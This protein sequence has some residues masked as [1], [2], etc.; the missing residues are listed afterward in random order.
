MVLIDGM[1]I[2]SGL[3][4]V[5]GLSGIPQSLI[6]RIEIVK[7]PASTLYGSEA[8]GGLINIITKS[9]YQAPLAYIE[10]FGTSWGEWNADASTKFNLS[11]KATTFI[12]I[13]HFKFGE[14]I[15]HNQDNF[16]DLTL[17]DRTSIF[18]KWTFNRKENRIFSIATRYVYEDRFGGELQWTPTFRGT[19]SIYGESIYTNRWELMG[20]YQLP[21]K[22]RMLFM[23]SLNSHFQ[24]SFYGK[25]PYFATQKISFSQ[26]TW[27]KRVGLKHDFLLGIAFRYTFYD[28]NTVATQLFDSL[29]I[30]NNPSSTYLPGIFVQDEI[31]V[32]ENSKLLLGLRYDYNSIFG[33]VFTPRANYKWSSKNKKN[34]IRLSTGSG[35]RVANVFTEDHAA[36]TGARKVTFLSDLKPETSWNGNINYVKK[37][38]FE[39]GE[40]VSFDLTAFYTH[41]GNKIIADYDTDP[42]QII[43][44]NLNGFAISKGISLNTDITLN[45][46]TALIGATLMEVTSTENGITERQKLTE[47]ISGTW[48]ISYNFNTLNIKIDYSGNV[49]SPMLLPTLGESDPRPTKSPWWSIQNVQITKTFKRGFECYVG[50]KNLLN[51]TPWK[52][53]DNTGII[54]R[55]FD[56]FDKKVQFDE[57][58]NAIKTEDNPCGLTFDPTYIYSPN[59]GIRGF[60]GIRYTLLKN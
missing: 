40:I 28:D 32:T 37:L 21:I 25:V 24:N 50:I 6:E 9:T 48:T 12:G 27:D 26:L 52:N 29:G 57:N 7:G 22:E 38:F 1:P 60:L 59:Q 35:Y 42:N 17:Q 51:W 3:S 53:I 20:T 54:S 44:T 46:I 45:N 18:N 34:I 30:E 19:D 55:S 16:T 4:T 15:D 31:K 5:Y 14:R 33:N 8:V 36:L 10:S 39:T 23:F 13:N 11:S 2:V 56:P 58:G 49:Y 41:F 43:Y 47:K